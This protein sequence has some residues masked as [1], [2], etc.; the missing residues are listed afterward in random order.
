MK[1][2]FIFFVVSFLL[3]GCNGSQTKFNEQ[4]VYS[5]DNVQVKS[6]EKLDTIERVN[7]SWV[8]VDYEDAFIENDMIFE[9]VVKNTTEVHITGS[10]NDYNIDLYKTI[11]RIIFKQVLLFIYER[12]QLYNFICKAST[13]LSADSI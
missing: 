1:K 4:V 11:H 8:E 9:G 12:K 3:V 5:G 2:L 13:Y 7:M 6:V 10:Y